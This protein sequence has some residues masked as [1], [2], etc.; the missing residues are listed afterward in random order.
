MALRALLDSEQGRE[1]CRLV[2]LSPKT[3]CRRALELS[4][5]HDLKCPVIDGKQLLRWD[6]RLRADGLLDDLRDDFGNAQRYMWFRE[7]LLGRAILVGG[8]PT[9]LELELVASVASMRQL[10]DE[11]RLDLRG[12]V[13]C[14]GVHPRP[15][16]V[17]DGHWWVRQHSGL[18]RRESG[19]QALMRLRLQLIDDD[20]RE[21]WIEGEKV[22]RPRLDL[23]RQSRTVELSLRDSSRVL[24]QGTAEIPTKTFIDEQIYGVEFREDVPEAERRR[25]RL[26]YLAWLGGNIGRTFYDLAL[27][28]GI[29]VVS[30]R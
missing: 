24:L 15:L 6:R 20:G 14:P 19:E 1:F 29:S 7:H 13:T 18:G 23:L 3:D 9:P 17:T 27:R 26:I 12:H 2:N 8:G 11:S 4:I 5:K 28:L 10:F 30:G 25:A 16:H 22:A 21:L